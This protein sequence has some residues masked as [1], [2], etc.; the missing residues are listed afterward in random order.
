MTQTRFRFDLLGIFQKDSFQLLDEITRQGVQKVLEMVQASR[1]Q[2]LASIEEPKKDIKASHIQ[3]RTTVTGAVESV[4]ISLEEQNQGT[5][6][7]ILN[8]HHCSRT[9]IV[10]SI[11]EVARTHEEHLSSKAENINARIQGEHTSTRELITKGLVMNQIVI[12]QEIQDLQHG[13]QRLQGEVDSK[14]TE[15]RDVVQQINHTPEGTGRQRLKDKGNIMTV[16]LMS[17][18]ELYK[19][20][21]VSEEASMRQKFPCADV[22]P[23]V[24]RA[25]TTADAYGVRNDCIEHKVDCTASEVNAQ[26]PHFPTAQR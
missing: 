14:I 25:I 9:E 1:D 16:T 23:E 10:T 2:T 17:L 12:K 22:S 19:D 13:L 11:G 4:G 3:T 15:L 20:L 21:Q 24:L 26:D 6:E 7:S 5:R 18:C 8:E